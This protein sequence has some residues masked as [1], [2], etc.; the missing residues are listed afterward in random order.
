MKA[1]APAPVTGVVTVDHH[2]PGVDA[3][4]EPRSDIRGTDG[5]TNDPAN[6]QVLCRSCNSRKG[7]WV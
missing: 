4:G 1:S 2:H 5:G 3:L 7:A 6:L